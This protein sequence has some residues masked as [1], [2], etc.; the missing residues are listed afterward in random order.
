MSTWPGGDRVSASARPE[1]P[2]AGG[3]NVETFFRL[4]T[5]TAGVVVDREQ[6]WRHTRHHGDGTP[7]R[8]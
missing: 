7:G 8:A 3:A 4:I 5:G 1:K 6:L 2:L